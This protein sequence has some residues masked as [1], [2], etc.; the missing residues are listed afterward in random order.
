MDVPSGVLTEII[1]NGVAIGNFAWDEGGREIIYVKFSDIDYTLA[2]G[3]LWEVD[4]ATGSRH[5]ITFNPDSVEAKGRG[6]E[7]AA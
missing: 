7:H 1:P 5:Q 6:R 4:I 2:N 3:T